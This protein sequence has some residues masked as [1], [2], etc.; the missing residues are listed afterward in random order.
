M[1]TQR[2]N[3]MNHNDMK[4]I[5]R[6]VLSVVAV[7]LVICCPT[8]GSCSG[9]STEQEIE[10]MAADMNKNLPQQVDSMTRLDR[11]E[12]GP[13]KAYSYVYTIN[14][15]LNDLEKE[16]VRTSATRGALTA[17][18]MQPIFDARDHRLVQVFRCGREQGA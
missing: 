14:R 4:R 18:E 17:P 6:M 11:V 8:V 7:G 5:A 2:E 16:Q 9:E 1:H 12:A 15:R 10:K 13:G 3:L